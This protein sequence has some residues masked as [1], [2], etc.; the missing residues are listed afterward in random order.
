MAPIPQ[1]GTRTDL[2]QVDIPRDE[3]T[4]KEKCEAKGGFW[5][6]ERQTCLLVK[7]EDKPVKTPTKKP[8]GTKVITGEGGEAGGIRL[9]DGRVLTGL[10]AKEV[11]QILQAQSQREP[12]TSQALL[13]QQQLQE[14]QQQQREGQQLAG[15]VGQ[16][17][18][19][20]ISPTGLNVGEAAIQGVVGSIPSALR[21]GAQLGIGAAAI[22]AVATAPVGG[23]GAIPAAAI[24][25]TVGFVAG[26]VGGMNSNFKSQR[27]DT[28]NAQQRV[29]DEGKQTLM[30]WVTLARADPTNREHYLGKYNQQSALI[31]Q[32]YRNMELDIIHDRVKRET[33]ITNIAEFETFYSE[34]GERDALDIE[35]RNALQTVSSEGY[36]MMEL[37]FRRRND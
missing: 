27:T 14:Q 4:P 17:G 36:D 18:E 10:S 21:L 35:M 7:P 12:L 25:A 20:P 23:I 29:L 1:F 19:L 26:I 28:T 22:G 34:G 13:G 8:T 24:G 11:E 32:A 3:R 15:G 5:D 31:D 37:A 16:F 6:E 33:G 2:G 9:P 30:D